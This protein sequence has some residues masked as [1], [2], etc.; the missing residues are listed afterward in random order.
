MI[1]TSRLPRAN[2]RDSQRPWRVAGD[3]LPLGVL[4]VAMACPAGPATAQPP[5]M[6]GGQ[7][8]G[9]QEVPG[10][11]LL[12]PTPLGPLAQG[13]PTAGFFRGPSYGSAW[14]PQ[15]APGGAA[16]G[17]AGLPAPRHRGIGEPLLCESW[18]YRPFSGGWFMGG[19]QGSPLVDDW[20]GQKSGFF[21]GYRLG[22]DYDHYWG[23][24]MRLAFGSVALFDSQRAKDA[25]QAADDA[26]GI[27]ADDPFRQRF[28]PRRD[29]N[30]LLWDVSFL[31]YPWGDAAWRP[32]LMA[33]LGTARID[34]VDRLSVVLDKTVFALPLACGLKYRWNDRLAL[35]L[36]LADNIAFGSSSGLNTLHN[37]SLT[38]GVEIRFGGT[39]KAYWPWN[40]GRHY[41]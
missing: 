1:L 38:A 3:W 4:L 7:A 34:F 26:R 2:H 21:A 19:M 6:I 35:R 9:R 25:Q 30:L 40:P 12:H 39:R 16:L 24:E 31:Y 11:F 14:Q 17:W 36:E 20:V 23:C 32:Y 27:A 10:E 15:F 29:C 28:D 41:W 22:W 13:P 5:D 18:R 37:L 33:G 8:S